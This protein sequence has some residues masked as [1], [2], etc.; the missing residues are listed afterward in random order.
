MIKRFAQVTAKKKAKPARA[1]I[2]RPVRRV[3]KR[4]AAQAPSVDTGTA[5]AEEIFRI[6]DAREAAHAKPKA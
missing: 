1:K 5:L 3:A 6:Y 4:S 2:V